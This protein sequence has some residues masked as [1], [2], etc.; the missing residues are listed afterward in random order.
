MPSDST[1]GLQP[2]LNYENADTKRRIHELIV[3]SGLIDH[4]E[5]IS[6]RPATEKE[7]ETVHAKEHIA[8][9]KAQ[10]AS[11]L[12]GDAGDL[13]TPFEIGRAHV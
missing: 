3:V 8:S 4:L 6:P 12:G 2:Y 13:T 11:R 7:L 10:S 9:I 5:R 1:S